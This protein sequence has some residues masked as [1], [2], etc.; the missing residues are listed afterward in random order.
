VTA[1]A[2]LRDRGFDVLVGHPERSPAVTREQLEGL[3]DAGALLQ[4]NASSVLGRHGSRATQR[5]LELAHSGLRD[6]LPADEGVLT[7]KPS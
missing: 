2:E 1:C 5:A 3:V 7:G 4:L 6:G